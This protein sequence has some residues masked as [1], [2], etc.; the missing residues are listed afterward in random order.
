MRK[1][2][3]STGVN[4]QDSLTDDVYKQIKDGLILLKNS[5]FDAADYPADKLVRIEGELT[6]YIE[7]VKR[8]SEE[9]GIKFEI[10]HLPFSTTICK[11]PDEIPPFNKKMYK[12]ID[13]AALL[14][15]DYAVLHPNT[16]TIYAEEFDRKLQFKSVTEHLAPFAEYAAKLNVKLAIENMRL[17]HNHVPVHRY[18]QEPDELCEVADFL[19]IGIC[20]DFGHANICGL[21]QSEALKYIGNRL[22]VLHVNDNNGVGDDHVAPFFGTVDWKD[23]MQ[24]LSD[25]GFNGLFN[26]EVAI[27][28][29]PESVRS[30]YARY[31]ADCAHEILTY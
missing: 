12:A 25:I 26:F 29:V 11:N 28:G 24:G 2:R 17:V 6:P 10:C 8:A 16:T 19:G 5:G 3:I 13:A 4:L 22:K 18:C 27:S 14:G 31:L 23:A 9:T 30:A 15:V 7:D 21:K 20:W 1:L